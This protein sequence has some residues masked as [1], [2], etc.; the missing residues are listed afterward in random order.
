M[1]M[2]SSLLAYLCNIRYLLPLHLLPY[3]DTRQA[4]CLDNFHIFGNSCDLGFVN[5]AL[6]KIS[7]IRWK[8]LYP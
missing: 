1:E 7:I 2:E 4:C 5:E 8:M 3:P 6:D